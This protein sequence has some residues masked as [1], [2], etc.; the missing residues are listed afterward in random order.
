MVHPGSLGSSA[1]THFGEIER[2]WRKVGGIVGRW[3]DGRKLGRPSPEADTQSMENGQTHTHKPNCQFG[4]Y[5]VLV[6]VVRI[7]GPP[8]TDD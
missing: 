3:E 1:H 2:K 7:P 6:V 4:L 5:V 8:T